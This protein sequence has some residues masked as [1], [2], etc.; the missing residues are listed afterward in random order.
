MV[1]ILTFLRSAQF[2]TMAIKL[3]PHLAEAYSN[4]GNV[5]KE[6]GMLK[7]A[8]QHYQHAGSSIIGLHKIAQLTFGIF[9]VD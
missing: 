1:N 4:L 8:L 2:S 3:N 9:L 5:Y 6:K 7:E